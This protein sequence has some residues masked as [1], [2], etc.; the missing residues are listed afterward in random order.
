MPG[1]TAG[2]R[3]FLSLV[4]LKLPVAVVVGGSLHIT[5]AIIGGR[6]DELIDAGGT[7][8]PRCSLERAKL[9]NDET[10]QAEP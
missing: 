7:M 2:N 5:R 9:S 4:Q 10:G 1:V 8:R 6:T 3:N